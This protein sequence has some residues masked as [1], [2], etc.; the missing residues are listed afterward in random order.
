MV[1]F[2]F[3]PLTDSDL[4]LSLNAHHSFLVPLHHFLF[5]HFFHFAL[6]LL[7]FLLP[8]LPP[9][10]LPFHLLVH[11]VLEVQLQIQPFRL[12]L[13]RLLLFLLLGRLS[14]LHAHQVGP[15][16]DPIWVA[17][18]VYFLS[19]CFLLDLV[20]GLFRHGFDDAESGAQRVELGSL[21]FF[22]QVFLTLALVDVLVDFQGGQVLLE[23]H[24][25]LVEVAAPEDVV[26]RLAV[27]EDGLEVEGEGVEDVDGDGGVD[28]VLQRALLRPHDAGGHADPH[29]LHRH[30]VLVFA[31]NHVVHEELQHRDQRQEL[32]ALRRL[33]LPHLALQVLHG[34]ASPTHQLIEQVEG[35]DGRPELREEPLH[36]IYIGWLLLA[37]M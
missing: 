21:G 24:L 34:Q 27:S 4:L 19:G 2:Y 31:G 10:W 6:R 16:D 8:H 26:L 5:F 13:R 36:Q 29:V 1:D 9:L 17:D 35:D 28:D 18:G 23:G 12:E 30:Q 15:V 3:L 22:E 11:Q 32:G 20:V 37:T 14:L 33:Q 7:H 25:L